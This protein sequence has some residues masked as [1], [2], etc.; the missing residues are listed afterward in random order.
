MHKSS[1]FL[2]KYIQGFFQ[3][4]NYKIEIQFWFIW[5]INWTQII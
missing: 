5:I 1:L 4:S 3:L 2:H